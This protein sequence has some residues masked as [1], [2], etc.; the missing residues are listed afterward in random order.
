MGTTK[1][2]FGFERPDDLVENP[3]ER[4]GQLMMEVIRVVYIPYRH[5]TRFF[6]SMTYLVPTRGD[7][8]IGDSVP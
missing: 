1:K 5:A 7:N 4:L 8:D 6:G 2:P 3:D